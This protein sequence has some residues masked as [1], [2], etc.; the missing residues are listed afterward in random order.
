LTLARALHVMAKHYGVPPH[1]LMKATP[2]EL[3]FSFEVYQM[4]TA[5]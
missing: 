5:E 3:S 2:A 4:A 1:E